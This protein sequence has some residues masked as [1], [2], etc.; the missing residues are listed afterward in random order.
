[1]YTVIVD[2]EVT[3]ALKKLPHHEQKRI[4]KKIEELA[5]KPRPAGVK[6]L[7]GNWHGF[8]RCRVGDYR[9]IYNVEEQV[10]T[11]CVVKVAHRGHVYAD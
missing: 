7:Q 2:K 4:L 6:A 8:Y 10:L 9:I 3:K 1:M 5:K 11:I